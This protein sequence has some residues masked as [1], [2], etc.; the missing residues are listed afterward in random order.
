M[1]DRKPSHQTR[2]SLGA[3]RNIQ[4]ILAFDGTDYHGW[5]IQND[6]PTVQGLVADAIAR[7]TGEKVTLT[8]SGRTDAGTHAR[9]LVANFLTGSRM[10]PG[11]FARALNSILPRDIRVL[12]AR[13]V[14]AGFHARKSAISKIYRYQIYLGPVLPPHMMR[15]YFHFPLPINIPAMVQAAGMFLGEHDFASFA[16]TNPAVI[17]TVRR[18]Y[19]CNLKK[20]GHRLLLT[21]EG[22]GFLQHMVRTMAGTL[23]EVG[24][25]AI[26]LADFQ[27]LFVKCDRTLAGFTAPAHGLVLLKVKY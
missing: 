21:V 1:Q 16:K 15:E 13:L 8:G 2:Q 23:L 25:G 20:S 10:K 12:S 14:P 27:D 24:R 19:R 9:G 4:L 22:N 6:S 26:S 17:S 11:Q 7:I 18:I 5:Q 3:K